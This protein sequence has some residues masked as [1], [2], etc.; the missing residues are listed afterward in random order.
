MWG[1]NNGDQSHRV[2]GAATPKGMGERETIADELELSLPQYF[3]RFMLK[4][5]LQLRA[6]CTWFKYALP[7]WRM[8]SVEKRRSRIDGCVLVHA[9]VYGTQ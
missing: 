6:P 7:L 4:V 3:T 9:R 5:A 1:S 2:N 8:K